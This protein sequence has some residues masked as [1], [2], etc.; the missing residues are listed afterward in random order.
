[1]R[2]LILAAALALSG[3]AQAANPSGVY[4]GSDRVCRIV[5]APYQSLWVTADVACIKFDGGYTLSLT[6]LYAPSQ[7]WSNTVAISLRPWAPDEY[8]AL[9]SYS[10]Q[11][12]QLTIVRGTDQLGVVNGVGT[13]E[14]WKRVV[15]IQSNYSC[16]GT[17]GM[18]RNKP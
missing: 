11:L 6:T 3:A 17:V 8:L 14:T 1:M 18:Q 10:Q 7:C 4:I 2:A 9:R 16:A 13:L 5:L 12:E 15:E